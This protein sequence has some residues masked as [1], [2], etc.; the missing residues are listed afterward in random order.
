MANLTAS[1]IDLAE[2]HDCFTIAEVLATEDL[3]FAERGGGGR[4]ARKPRATQSGH[5]H[6]ERQR[7]SEIERSSLGSNGTGQVVEV[8]KQLVSKPTT[9]DRSG[10]PKRRTT[11]EAQ[12]RHA[13]SMSSGGSADVRRGLDGLS[14]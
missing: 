8:F 5:H 4:F 6:G 12:G 13:P 7:W 11:L 2:V 14:R 3:G 10:M 9:D 1:E